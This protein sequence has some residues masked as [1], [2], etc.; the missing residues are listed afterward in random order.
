MNENKRFKSI[1]CGLQGQY[2]KDNGNVLTIDDV[3]NRLNELND[4]NQDLWKIIRIYR[5]LATCHNC[6]YHDCDWYDEGDEFE[7]CEKG[8]D[9]SYMICSEWEEL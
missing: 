6:D 5:K 1:N 7:V 8:N 2:I 4:E 3:V 9:M